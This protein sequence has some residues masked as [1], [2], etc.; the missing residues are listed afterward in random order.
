MTDQEAFLLKRAQRGSEEAFEALIESYENGIYRTCLRMM[1][2]NQAALDACQETFIKLYRYVGTFK[3]DSAFSTWVYRVTS[4]VCLDELRK[5][6]RKSAASLDE[7]EENGHF[8][9]M[10]AVRDIPEE[11][12]LRS[13]QRRVLLSALNHLNPEHK[14]AIVL[15]DI[16]GF[17]YDEI[18]EMLDIS[19]G[20]LK[21]RISRARAQLREQLS[22]HMELLGGYGV[23]RCRRDEHSEL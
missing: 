21:S 7:M 1:G 10:G 16:Q 17:S 5:R 11:D 2:E 12:L 9:S 13:E 15:R 19:L 4:N 3:G 14:I 22:P 8:E 20:T 6:S 18:A 23:K